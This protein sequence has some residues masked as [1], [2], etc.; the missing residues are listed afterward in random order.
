[1]NPIIKGKIMEEK[2]YG[3]YLFKN[4]NN[5]IFKKQYMNNISNMNFKQKMKFY[6]KENDLNGI[7]KII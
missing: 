6:Q 2:L 5:I 7:G 3:L 4:S 1:M